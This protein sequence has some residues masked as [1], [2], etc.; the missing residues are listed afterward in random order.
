MSK[1]VCDVCG[2]VYDEELGDSDLGIEAGTKFEDLAFIDSETGKSLINTSFD[3]ENFARPNKRMEEMLKNAEPY[4][5]IGVHN[6]LGSSVPSIP[7]LKACAN[8]KYKY[9]IVICHNG[10][11]Y[12]YSV[13]NNL[14]NEPMASSALDRLEK[15][16][17]N[18]KVNELFKNAGIEMEVL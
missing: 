18:S 10:T 2:W 3:K 11:I 1:Y 5:I 13:D 15:T 14:F 7:D 4:T 6:H 8:R 17:Y 9:G 12:K 16:G